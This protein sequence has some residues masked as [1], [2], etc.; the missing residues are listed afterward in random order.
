MCFSFLN[1]PGFEDTAKE[2]TT[3]RIQEMSLPRGRGIFSSTASGCSS[4][5]AMPQGIGCT[6]GKSPPR[7]IT[8]LRLHLFPEELIHIG[9]R[10]IKPLRTPRS[11]KP[12]NTLSPGIMG[13][14]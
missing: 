14:S 10:G 4:T 6:I 12:L 13:I 3:C 5:I 11:P 1:M 2:L 8:L 9:D 7:E